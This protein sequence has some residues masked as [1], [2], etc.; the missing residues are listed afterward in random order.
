MRKYLHIF[1]T[2][3]KISSTTYGGGY[4]MV[5]TME[6]ELVEQ[7]K[8]MNDDDYFEII[9]ICQ[10]FPGPLAI[11]SSGFIGYRLEGVGGAIAAILGVLVPSFILIFIISTLLLTFDQNPV[12]QAAL[13]GI[14]SVVPM[15]ILLAIVK[16]VAKFKKNV[17]NII[18][19]IIAIIALEVFNINPAIVIIVAAAYGLLVFRFLFKEDAK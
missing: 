14:D 4:A 6:R 10:T 15:L 1:L 2:Y 18:A 3:L 8:L 7:Q 16:F 9:G 12:V 19:A 11:T 13:T 5:G 17:H